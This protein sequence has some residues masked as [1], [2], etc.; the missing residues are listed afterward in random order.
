MECRELTEKIIGD[1]YKA[2]NKLG[3]GFL[4]SVHE[5]ALLIEK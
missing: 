1:A 5:K 4:E 3:Y 2:Y